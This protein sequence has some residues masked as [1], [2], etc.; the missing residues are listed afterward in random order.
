MGDL[1]RNYLLLMLAVII[2]H[3]FMSIKYLGLLRQLM[4]CRSISPGISWMLRKI[5][6]W[7]LNKLR[8]HLMQ[9]ER[10]A[11]I[12]IVITIKDKIS[13]RIKLFNSFN[14]SHKIRTCYRTKRNQQLFKQRETSSNHT[15]EV[16]QPLKTSNKT[17]NM[18]LIA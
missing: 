7:R 6:I 1:K 17:Q 18:L 8:Y 15:I 14:Q 12:R 2:P 13:K 4:W 11:F 10:E 9:R 3:H 5:S 16:H